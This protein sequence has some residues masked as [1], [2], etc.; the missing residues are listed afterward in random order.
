MPRTA[1]TAHAILGLLALRPSWTTLEITR[2]L[3][4]NMRFFWP[5]VES[6]IYAELRALEARGL[7]R[8]RREYVGRRGRSVY[9]LT[10]PG[11]AVLDRW[12]ELPPRGTDLQCEP[13]LRVLLADLQSP[14]QLV[15]AIDTVRDDARAILDVGER[16][17]N[18]Y[19][20]GRGP[21][22]DDVHARALVFDFL[23]SHALMLLGWADRA[24]A[25]VRS[26]EGLSAEERAG[27]AVATVSACLALF[28]PRP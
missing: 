18:E 1:T 11:R 20:E 19:Q 2:Q 8:S 24:E 7:I 6:R 10:A 15:R 4:R 21:F 14:E 26:W 22:Q 27:R 25:A 28:P 9:A 12:L 3:R 23:S 13:V 16:V 17:G 5:R